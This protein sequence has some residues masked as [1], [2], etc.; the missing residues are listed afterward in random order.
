MKF[1]DAIKMAWSIRQAKF[2]F[3]L[4]NSENRQGNVLLFRV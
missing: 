1:T 2:G 3:T 4:E